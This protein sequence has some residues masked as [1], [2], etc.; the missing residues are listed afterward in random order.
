MDVEMV[1][2]FRLWLLEMVPFRDR[3]DNNAR[4][5]V[6]GGDAVYDGHA[7]VDQQCRQARRGFG[8]VVIERSLR[9]ELKGSGVLTFQPDGVAA[10]S[11]FRP[12]TSWPRKH[13]RASL[14]E[15]GSQRDSL[16]WLL[17]ASTGNKGGPE[18]ILT[19]KAIDVRAG[20]YFSICECRA[21]W[22]QGPN[23][24]PRNTGRRCAGHR[25]RACPPPCAT[26]K[27]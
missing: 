10:S 2:V 7:R 17:G 27:S 25:Y 24:P 6:E 3:K 23:Y 15:P 19:A 16:H 21:Q 12:P 14:L 18:A 4:I 1:H 13:G 26:S 8:S 20:Y 5:L 9:H 11:P 22:Q